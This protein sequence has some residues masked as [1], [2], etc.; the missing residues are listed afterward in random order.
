MGYIF[1]IKHCALHSK[2]SLVAVQVS[3]APGTHWCV[4]LKKRRE[5]KHILISC[6]FNQNDTNAATAFKWSSRFIKKMEEFIGQK[7]KYHFK[8]QRKYQCVSIIGRKVFGHDRFRSLE[9]N[10]YQYKVKSL[11]TLWRFCV[12]STSGPAGSRFVLANSHFLSKMPK[13]L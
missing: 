12:C 2:C 4:Q 5:Y 11:F 3:L 6:Q 8:H 1:K 13:A 10:H 9:P 7:I